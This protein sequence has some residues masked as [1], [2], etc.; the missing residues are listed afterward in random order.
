[1]KLSQKIALGIA[2]V[3]AA[4]IVVYIERRRSNTKRKLN[5]IA[6]EGYETAHDILFPDEEVQGRHLRFGPVIPG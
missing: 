2:V 4:G 5:Q 3:A 6:D 1:M